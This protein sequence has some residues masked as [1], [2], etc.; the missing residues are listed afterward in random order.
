[1]L[2]HCKRIPAVLRLLPQP[3]CAFPI[4]AKAKAIMPLIPNEYR[5]PSK[6]DEFFKPV[7]G[8]NKI[9]ILGGIESPN[10]AAVGFEIWERY[11]GDEK[12]R[13]HRFRAD[14]P[15]NPRPNSAVKAIIQQNHKKH[16]Q[17]HGHVMDEQEQQRNNT[18]KLFWAFVVWNYDLGMIQVW[19]ITQVTIRNYLATKMKGPWGD[20][21]DRPKEKNESKDHIGYDI[22]VIKSE[23]GPNKQTSYILDWESPA[24]L[25]KHIIQALAES[26]VDINKL[27]EGEYPISDSREGLL[28]DDI[29]F[30][31]EA[32]EARL[33]KIKDRKNPDLQR[34]P[35]EQLDY[36]TFKFEGI[37]SQE[38]L[39]EMGGKKGLQRELNELVNTVRGEVDPVELDDLQAL[40]NDVVREYS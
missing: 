38:Q 35:E 2:L 29:P 14:N 8:T 9:R 7:E 3:V 31:Q 25:E 22:Y 24:P 30:D 12:D 27:F 20:P 1:M 10:L 39:Q 23:N 6:S 13:P 28:G 32:V 18:S 36:L 21:Y 34:T 11:R 33:Q 15:K 19:L 17:L 16:E 37:E 5:E 4:Q 40:L 26:E